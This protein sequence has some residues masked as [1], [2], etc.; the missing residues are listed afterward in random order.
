MNFRYSLN[1]GVM[2]GV[3]TGSGEQIQW[4]TVTEGSKEGVACEY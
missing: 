2:G 3:S 4:T 1:D